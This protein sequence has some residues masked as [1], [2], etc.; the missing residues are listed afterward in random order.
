MKHSQIANILNTQVV[1]N[2]LGQEVTVAEDLSNIVEVGTL[3]SAMT[4]DTLKNFQKTLVV[5][6]QNEVIN[7]MIEEKTFG[8]L[9][10]SEMYGAG[11]QRIMNSG[12]LTAQDSH[13][14]NL[15]DGQNYLDGKFYGPKTSA[16]IYEETK[17]FKVAHSVSEDNF[18]MYFMDAAGV[19]AYF[20]LIEA[21][22]QNTIRSEIN[23]LEKRVLA[24]LA[25]DAVKDG[26][27]VHS[28][29]EFNSEV[30]G[31]TT[32]QEGYKTYDDIKKD[33]QLRAYFSDYIKEITHLI[34]SAMTDVN[35]KYNDGTVETFAPAS[36]INI[37]LLSKI[38]ADVK[39]MADPVDYS[40]PAFND[41]R[42]INAWQNPG[43]KLLP[44]LTSASSIKVVT[45]GAESDTVTNVVG[46]IFDKYAAGITMKRSKTTV[47]EVGAEGFRTIFNHI[48]ANFYE[49]TRLGAVAIALD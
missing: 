14:L 6:V 20:A 12:R 18:A 23:E 38:A 26:R 37:V 45:D 16:K 30:L 32:G 13:L 9:K 21:N 41:Y 49:D 8:I 4:S 28:V 22:V 36:D 25:Y 10:D 11:K 44:D 39:F 17:A 40:I 29:T 47:E 43:N 46:L 5:G 2:A 33:R 15:V 27:V 3:V 34:P 19:S 1:Q 31:A 24:K 35:E 7:R 42:E 48:A